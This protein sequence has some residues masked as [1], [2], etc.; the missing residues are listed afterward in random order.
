MKIILAIG[1]G[2]F[3]GGVLRYLMTLLF[4]G[5]TIVGIPL[6]TMIVNIL[7]CLFIGLLVGII[8][9]FDISK[10]WELFI[11]T[12]VIGSFTTFSTFSF[13]TIELIK[14]KEYF[15]AIIYC[16]SSVLFGLAATFFGIFI[17]KQL[18]A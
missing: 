15:N 1:I 6:G 7:G 17:T 4:Q 8:T 10:K 14:T 11:I 13:E 9:N 18:I 3:I 5:K 2:S 16:S 12:G